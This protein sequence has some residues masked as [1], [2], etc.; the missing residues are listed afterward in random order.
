M[1]DIYN[2]S[3]NWFNWSFENP[4]IVKPNHIALYFF[5]IEHCNRLGWKEKFGLPTS[6]AMEA[7]GIK[8]YNT[9][10]KTLDE[11]VSFGFIQMIETS[12]NQYSSN[13]IALSKKAKAFD[14]AL[15]KALIKHTTKHMSK[16]SES[17][18][19][20]TCQSIDSIDIQVYNNTN[21]QYYNEEDFFIMSENKVSGSATFYVLNNYMTYIESML[22]NFGN[23]NVSLQRFI[24]NFN[25]HY[26]NGAVF[27]DEKHL[28]NTIKSSI[29]VLSATPIP[30]EKTKYISQIPAEENKW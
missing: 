17:T 24:D 11:I 25:L 30:I 13:I 9:Y 16:Q 27:T 6:M 14:K 23:K 21:L 4:D 5:C 26:P 3:R 1:L 10:K 18:Q 22:M 28:R 29:K 7:I 20:S 19:Q 8:S 2:L 12:K 15:D